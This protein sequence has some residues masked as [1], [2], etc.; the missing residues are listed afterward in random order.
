MMPPLGETHR[1]EG[2][3]DTVGI[4]R[5][6]RHACGEHPRGLG[7]SMSRGANV[8]FFFVF[9][10]LAVFGLIMGWQECTGALEHTPCGWVETFDGWIR[11]CRRT[12]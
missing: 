9:G 8:L 12:R 7:S 11:E 3:Y 5:R 6:L 10:V 2:E 4:L 1:K